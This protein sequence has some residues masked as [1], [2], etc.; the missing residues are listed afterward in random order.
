M[1]DLYYTHPSTQIPLAE[2]FHEN[3]KL[4]P[5]SSDAYTSSFG[6]NVV[7][8]VSGNVKI[9]A[10]R[11]GTRT[12]LPAI[13]HLGEDVSN[14]LGRRRS[15]RSYGTD[16]VTLQQVGQLLGWSH[17]ILARPEESLSTGRSAP[18]AGALYPI[19]LYV[20]AQ[21]VSGLLPAVY[22]YNPKSHSLEAVAADNA[23][24]AIYRAS[25]YPEI[26]SR[27]NLYVMMVAVFART[28]Q[29]YGE[30]GYRFVLLDCGHVA[31]NL[32][33]VGTAIGLG[34]VGIGGFLDDPLNDVLELDGV[35]EAVVHTIALGP[36]STGGTEG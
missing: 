3:S 12:D 27:A 23:L 21:G 26:V 24:Q 34:S 35:N 16:P 8:G 1:N 17:G 36:F 28:C 25:L 33:L 22:H 32:H 18:S 31:Q 2:L 13:S 10:Y 7:A 30:R 4:P 15:V 11:T 6:Q 9:K 5:R 29:K 14:I 19:E 20:A